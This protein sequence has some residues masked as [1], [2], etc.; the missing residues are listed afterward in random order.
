VAAGRRM[1]AVGAE[2]VSE[3]P[4]AHGAASAAEGSEAV[5]SV[6]AEASAVAAAGSA[7]GAA[8]DAGKTRMSRFARIGRPLMASR[9][10]TRALFPPPALAQIEAACAAAEARHEGEIRFAIET[11]L[12]L[13]ALW[14]DL[15][16]RARA[17]QV[18]ARLHIWDTRE[19]NGVLIY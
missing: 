17:L 8:R 16:P 3:D 18:F 14:H 4:W 15:S 1:D 13:E 2:A 19:N 7:G 12:P 11:A 10:R 5:G 9:L 6:E